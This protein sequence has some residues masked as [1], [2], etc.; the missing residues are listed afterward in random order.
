MCRL[1]VVLLAWSLLPP[2]GRSA[3]S[4]RP[5]PEGRALAFLAREV[6]RWSAE[7]KCF[8]C[9][10]NG[11][12]ARALYAAR[13]AGLAVP[14]KALADTTRWLVRPVSWD[15][16]GGEGPYSDK[17]LARLQFTAALAEAVAAGRVKDQKPL[18]EAARLVARDQQEDG[19]WQIDA[20][21][22]VGSPATYGPCLAT[23][24]GRNVLR[25]ADARTFTKAI[26]RADRWLRQ[27]KARNVLEA[28]AVLLGLEGDRDEAA[29]GQRAKCLALLRKGQ[30]R[31]GGWGPYVTA[32]SEPF[33]TALVLLALA[34]HRG[35][36]G[37]RDMIRRGRAYLVAAQ[38]DGGSWP[39]TTRPAGRTSYAQQL[40]TTGWATL[41]LLA[42]GDRGK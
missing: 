21:G 26:A 2:C 27:V 13:R 34:R 41:A 32:A 15:H 25:R 9:H 24:L 10:N 7:N 23:V 29:A 17:K 6:P 36:D 5:T 11:D 22:S 4:R 40:S 31:D 14:A 16:N 18:L 1:A 35:A 12:A 42:T 37:I 28:A 8:S 38:E 20:G 33:D 19:S 39:E 3:E 30:S